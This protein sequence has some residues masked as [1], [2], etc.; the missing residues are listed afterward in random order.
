MHWVL[1]LFHDRAAWK[2]RSSD[3]VR[4]SVQKLRYIYIGNIECW[5]G[6]IKWNA[7]SGIILQQV[8]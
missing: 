2:A 5:I 3:R 7:H 8:R 1:M 6:I 4:V